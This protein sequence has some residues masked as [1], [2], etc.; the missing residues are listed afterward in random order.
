MSHDPQHHT[1]H[2]TQS[3]TQHTQSP[4]PRGSRLRARRAVRAGAALAAAVAAACSE[5][6]TAPSADGASFDLTPAFASLPQGYASVPTSYAGTAPAGPWMAADRGAGPG[7]GALMGGGLGGAFAG[8]VAFGRGGGHGPFGGGVGCPDGAFDAASGRVVCPTA[9]LPNGLTITRSAAYANAAG[10]VQQA[11]DSATTNTVNLRTATSGTVAFDSSSGRGRGGFGFAA[12][13]GRGH[14]GRG[15]RGGA[16]GLFLGD[17]ATIV[18]ATVAVE[19]ASERT[20]SG[21]AAG[22]ARR[23]VD[24]ASSSRETTT[25]TS[26]RGAFTASRVAGD[27]TRGLVVPVAAAGAATYP[28]AGTVI[29]SMRATL[30]YAGGEPAT[31]SRREVLTYDGSATATLVVTEDGVSRT[32]TVALPR[33][34]PACE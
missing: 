8:G 7:R 20:T 1:Q 33:G 26:S 16:G 22:S 19:N 14:G 12:R 3:P 5:G 2:H 6:S 15:G 4:T 28:T 29:R 17:T 31:A 32:C 30:A 27:T 24:G 9:T 18:S 11:F 10:Q 23:T 25:G 13:G 21:L 34:R